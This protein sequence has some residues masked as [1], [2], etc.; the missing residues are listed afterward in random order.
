M[1]DYEFEDC[2]ATDA[3]LVD[4]FNSFLRLPT[5]PEPIKFNKEQGVF[6]VDNNVEKCITNQIKALLRTYTVPNPIYDAVK[7]AAGHLSTTQQQANSPEINIDTNFTVTCLDR[8]QGLQ[9]IKQERLPVFLQS[10]CYF[11]Y[12]LAK[13][14]SQLEWSSRGVKLQID[15]LYYPWPPKREPTPVPLTEDEN[16]KIMKDFYVSLGQTSVTEAEEWFTLAKK[17]QETEP[18]YSLPEPLNYSQTQANVHLYVYEDQSTACSSYSSSLGIGSEEDLC[19]HW[20][21][22]CNLGRYHLPQ[23]KGREDVESIRERPKSMN[24]NCCIFI[25]NPTSEAHLTTFVDQK[26]ESGIDT[27][28]DQDDHSQ[29]DT[30]S[31]DYRKGKR[32][33][34]QELHIVES[35]AGQIKYAY[36]YDAY[37]SAFRIWEEFAVTF[38]EQVFQAA[39]T[40]LF[41]TVSSSESK[42][43]NLA[44][45]GLPRVII[46]DFS[47]QQ[48][49]ELTVAYKNDSQVNNEEGK[50]NEVSSGVE[51][52]S[53]M[54]EYGTDEDEPEEEDYNNDGGNHLPA[55]GRHHDFQS[56]KGF[57]R[58]KKFLLG[59]PGEKYWS[60]WIDIERLKVIMETARKK[61]HLRI[62]KTTYLVS[63]GEHFLNTEILSRLGVSDAALWTVERLCLIQ[64]DVLKP[65]LLYWGPRYCL[66]GTFSAVNAS[67]ELRTW[68]ERQLRPKTNVEPHPRSISL[69]P[70]RAKSSVP[71]ITVTPSQK[72]ESHPP[73][74][75]SE[76]GVVSSENAIML[77]SVN[78]LSPKRGSRSTTSSSIKKTDSSKK[79]HQ[80]PSTKSEV[81][82]LSCPTDTS[83]I[84]EMDNDSK[85]RS[86]KMAPDKMS[87]SSGAVGNS[88]METM[89]QALHFDCKAG[90]FFM[91]FC[92]H[93]GN[94]LWNHGI[95]FWFDLQEYL[96]LFYQEAFHP[97]EIKKQAHFLYAKYVVYG[98]SMDTG[99]DQTTRNKIYRNLDPPFEDLF[100][101]AEDY[102]LTLLLVP[103]VQMSASE[104]ATYKKVELFEQA[105]KT[106]SVYTKKLK[107]LQE[108]VHGKTTEG[109][110]SK[111]NMIPVP[112]VPKEINL[113]NNVPEEYRHYNF[114]TL[115]HNRLELQKFR[116]FLEDNFASMDLLCWMDIE[117]FRRLPHKERE[118]REEK[119]KEIKTKY[120]NKKYFFGPNSPATRE[121]QEQVI[122]LGGGWGKI[123]Q[124]V[125]P[126]P[127]VIDVQKYVKHRLEKKWLPLFLATSE[128]TERQKKQV[129]IHDIA[130]D[131]LLLKNRKRRE[132][133]RNLDNKWISSSKEIIA[134]RKALLNPVTG[135]QFQR[136]VSLKGDYLESG[137]LFW[138][139]VQKYKDMCHSHIDD[140]AIQNKINTIIGC[141]INSSIPPA[142]QIDIPQ[143]QA[144]QIIQKKRELGPYVFREAQMTVFG[145]LF[146]LWPAFCEFRNNLAEDNILPVL[147]RK[148]EKKLEKLKRKMKEEE[149][150][151]EEAIRKE[152]FIEHIYGDSDSNCSGSQAGELYSGND[153]PKYE[154]NRHLSWS[155]SKYMEALEQ[156]N[157]LSQMKCEL[158]RKSGLSSTS[159]SLSAD[160][161]SIRT[162][163]TEISK[164]SRKS[165]HSFSQDKIPQRF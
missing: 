13:L 16:E 85:D 106:E 19:S 120:L 144:E 136:F 86:T 11:E 33:E 164:R 90:Y 20:V 60:L 77:L 99:V 150:K 34:S 145:V 160:V 45:L 22:P 93:S 59:T 165:I 24:E 38:V 2:L 121:Q 1:R 155:Y 70:L 111:L 14:M 40:H 102:V 78:L 17:S 125:L 151:Q 65:L 5:F 148:K 100:D 95:H 75:P 57:E 15:P 49:P 50:A 107:A 101:P 47:D 115:I 29:G 4:Y 42:E 137:V 79:R 161:L 152:N 129:Q 69:L 162:L 25:H 23:P 32:V 81:S 63:S 128:F 37:N 30:D 96:K 31:N 124:S 122:H 132:V 41:G 36:N 7:K 134:F 109:S 88:N 118:K 54:S 89:L 158:E 147:K 67:A 52:D 163:K 72:S 104:T 84:Q 66:T 12:R 8:E 154:S 46:N 27:D 142:L 53:L 156:E 87:R 113:W 51:D 55:K 97:F 82:Y 92:E 149:I 126:S 6:E 114:G 83:L 9:W 62:M 3:L 91:R 21:T 117:Q 61:R 94:K 139:E 28:T 74:S 103:W 157:M 48:P 140:A 71:K 159:S 10:D 146:K 133:W 119:S 108:K 116:E 131:H 130:E 153:E 44:S 112:D 64:P 127:V 18:A 105:R 73:K 80:L 141:F 43:Q 68:K 39:F 135:L 138:L 56:Q 143:E 26:S 98:A 110:I 76:S 35:E 123:L 58:F